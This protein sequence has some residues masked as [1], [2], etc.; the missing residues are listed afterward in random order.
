MAVNELIFIR[1]VSACQFLET[2]V[3]LDFTKIKKMAW[4]QMSV[5]GL[6]PLK[7]LIFFYFG[8]RP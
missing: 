8:K 1:L 7:A 3:T 6:S 2:N 5:Q 4:S